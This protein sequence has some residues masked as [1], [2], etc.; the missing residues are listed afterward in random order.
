MSGTAA[1]VDDWIVPGQRAAPPAPADDW[2]VPGAQQ[3]L[4]QGPA[5]SLGERFM[6]NMREGFRG[7]F[8]GHA[9]D[10]LAARLAPDTSPIDPNTGQPIGGPT[11]RQ[12]V[13]SSIHEDQ[14]RGD[15]MPSF[16]EA[17][18]IGGQIAQAAVS[19]PGQLAGGIASPESLIPGIGAVERFG[20]GAAR[21]IM[22]I[23]RRGLVTG[24]E[25]AVIQGGANVAGQ[26]AA[27]GAGTQDQF[28][29]AEAA[30]AAVMGGGLGALM[31]AA[32]EMAGALMERVRA[33]RAAVP[34]ATPE[35]VAAP[36]TEPEIMGVLTPQESEAVTR[37]SVL[38]PQ[39]TQTIARGPVANEAV[40][41]MPDEMPPVMMS[42]ASGM[43]APLDAETKAALPARAANDAVAP[44]AERVEP[45]PTEPA[46]VTPPAAEA[47]RA[48]RVEPAPIEP[49]PLA[50]IEPPRAPEPREPAPPAAPEG[51][52]APVEPRAA[53]AAAPDAHT[54][55]WTRQRDQ[56][57]ARADQLNRE[58]QELRDLRTQ[59]TAYNGGKDEG[60]M[61]GSDRLHGTP[62]QADQQLLS[63]I[64][65]KERGA[66]DALGRQR[67][68]EAALRELDNGREP[69]FKPS[70][71]NPADN[72]AITTA[73]PAEP[74][75][76]I[77]AIQELGGIKDT[78][79]D[80][81]AQDLHK[82]P[83]VVNN[84]TGRGADEM[85][86][87]L[88]ERGFFPE[89][90]ADEA[91]RDASRLDGP[92][93]VMDAIKREQLGEK[94][95]P[96]DTMAAH[97]D[98]VAQHERHMSDVEDAAQR[99]GLKPEEVRGLTRGQLS[100]LTAERSS[101]ADRARMAAEQ[102]AEMEAAQE[103]ARHAHDD[104]LAKGGELPVDYER[105][106]SRPVTQEDVERE[107]HTDSGRTEPGA[108]GGGRSEQDAANAEPAGGRENEVGGGAERGA[109]EPG[110]ASGAREEGR[111]GADAV[112]GQDAAAAEP[113]DSGQGRDLLGRPVEEPK[114]KAAP[115]T[116]QGEFPGTEG[117]TRQAVDARENA[118][119][120]G[121]G[122]QAG[123]EGFDLFDPEARKQG[124][125]GKLYGG[126]GAIFDP[127]AWK[128][129]A[130]PLKGAAQPFI[131]AFKE[132]VD[133]T[134]GNFRKATKAA[135]APR[136]KGDGAPL[137]ARIDNALPK[138]ARW[139][140]QAVREV[141][142]G[143]DSAERAAV[144][145]LP[146]GARDAG[147]TI[148]D[149]FH[150]RA[151]EAKGATTTYREGV[152]QQ[153]AYFRN[154]LND[155]VGD[156]PLTEAE[157]GQ[158]VKQ[159]QNPRSIRA[160]TR[161][162]D[163]AGGIRDLNKELH[164]YQK[165]AGIDLGFVKDGYFQR[166]YDIHE[167]TK[168]PDAFMRD[169][170]AQA[171]KDGIERPDEF[172]AAWRMHIMTDGMD[173]GVLQTPHDGLS[174]DHFNGRTLGKSADENLRRWL[175]QDPLQVTQSYIDHAV[176]RAEFNRV[177]EYNS[178][179]NMRLPVDKRDPAP[180][181]TRTTKAFRG[182]ESEMALKRI[183]EYIGTITGAT[184]SR[185]PE[186]ARN[187]LDWSRV[188]GAESFMEH[189]AINSMPE[190]MTASTRTGNPLEFARQVRAMAAYATGTKRG[191]TIEQWARKFG[192]VQDTE[193]ASSRETGDFGSK[194]ADWMA[195]KYFRANGL[196]LWSHMMNAGATDRGMQF[197]HTMAM[198]VG[199]AGRSGREAAFS[200]AELGISKERQ[201]AFR[202]WIDKATSGGKEPMS[203]YA[204][205]NAPKDLQR[206]YR[207]GTFRFTRQTHM[208]PSP[209]TRPGWANNPF[210]SAIAF[211]SNY[212]YA[213]HTNVLMRGVRMLKDGDLH[214]ADKAIMGAKMG[215]GMLA[216]MAV[217]RL[218][219]QGRQAL[220]NAE[221]GQN[222]DVDPM[223]AVIFTLSRGQMLGGVDP[224]MELATGAL[225]HQELTASMLGPALGR[226]GTVAQTFVNQAQGYDVRGQ[227][228]TRARAEYD[229]FLK[230]IAITAS[231]FLPIQVAAAVVQ[232]AGSSGLRDRFVDA[233]AGPDAVRRGVRDMRAA[234]LQHRK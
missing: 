180:A 47:P 140:T 58:A 67:V 7:T 170:A 100:D 68:A 202:D 38:T 152:V 37:P 107:Q 93:M 181:W 158:I 98:E 90:K 81:R 50:P 17:P 45:P 11:P 136:A 212:S 169:V 207:T 163:I 71:A 56:A 144:D 84:K 88:S 187:A 171:R 55:A 112:P 228:R 191:L 189:S 156:K 51:P 6:E 190:A 197:L 109:G 35:S 86:R 103:A 16:T 61:P 147:H 222:R 216:T 148:L 53:E 208:M 92:Q 188:W 123:V 87:A 66:A 105:D 24:G 211:L 63:M 41:T 183:G 59:R 114:P 131:S 39:E 125:L 69:A 118:P 33:R 122:P 164:A 74:R 29:G 36:V 20:G 172:A 167:I 9:T 79:G 159:L 111:P 141:T 129:M 2:V 76:I 227:L 231:F 54:A 102:D 184:R 177:M 48:P 65:G 201:A 83:G 215:M 22:G 3:S 154:K 30:G 78:G 28:S 133:N 1:A 168:N 161:L 179:E 82:I 101:L 204:Y 142:Y 117:A 5:P 206:M 8:L 198:R 219:Y 165:E 96:A 176:R 157:A 104:F 232:I 25:Q 73:A 166:R 57:A 32:P 31:H 174:A 186:W 108:E 145:R 128:W 173:R 64:R 220:S 134:I 42:E 162:G 195:Q 143:S 14:A 119:L 194:S 15:L 95:V 18:T 146:Q 138:P 97:A 121:K 224:W 213:L 139:A 199:D 135:E 77:K 70:Y 153:R 178:P 99:L 230:P 85:A 209:E 80:L 130:R 185:V 193:M 205:D 203:F 221:T 106:A 210:G 43:T 113:R 4:T 60:S 182:A 233:Q 12:Q 234:R 89:L 151:G 21:S 217:S 110:S 124:D 34:G 149:K 23:A 223:T 19:L 137:A 229:A 10:A 40:R 132:G 116:R 200:L 94:V 52:P 120:K 160:G 49:T 175:V 72:R 46:P 225:Y 218:L 13:V 127:D 75:S 91:G 126:P 155:I 44:P 214:G 196:E 150:A 226:A 62:R 27:V 192:T 26:A 115:D